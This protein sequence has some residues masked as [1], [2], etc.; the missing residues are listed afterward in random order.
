MEIFTDNP[1]LMH[2]AFFVGAI[3]FSLLINSLLLKFSKNLGTRQKDDLLRWSAE[4]K[5]SVG[6]L[7]FFILFL[8]SLTIMS[9]LELSSTNID[10]EMQIGLF[11][12]TTLGFL[13]GLADDA[14]NTQPLLKFLGQLLCA[15]ILFTS[16]ISIELTPDMY[17]NYIFTILWV[18]GIMNSINMLDNMDGI[19]ASVAFSII[20]SILVVI[21]LHEGFTDS[22]LLLGL[23]VAAA[24]VGFLVFN[25][26]P[27]KM[28]MGDT[29]SQF[30]GVFL[31]GISIVYLWNFK[32]STAEY[33]QL[34][35]FLLPLLAFIIPLIDTITV[36]MRRLFKGRSPFIGGRDH[37]T[38]HL[39]YLGLSDGQVTM[40]MLIISLLSAVIIYF[41]FLLS[42]SWNYVYTYVVIGYFFLLLII[43]QVLYNLGG[44][45]KKIIEKTGR[46]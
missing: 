8:I 43:M 46:E 12:A 19:T 28:F 21:F 18:I 38:H 29:G 26:H 40:V 11:S 14:F 34:K 39:A 9:L 20:L 16:G 3:L 7:S 25:W 31:A 1:L 33:I 22:S 37:T 13:I 30:L 24:L 45:R 27:A 6:G 32:A 42:E 5:P 35:Q 36:F 2:L 17:I 4:S 41:V 23:G 10:R 15:N 44:K